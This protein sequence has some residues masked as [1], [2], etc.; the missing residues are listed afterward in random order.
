MKIKALLLLG[1][2][3]SIAVPSTALAG[4][5][6]LLNGYGAESLGM[7]GADVAVSR[8]S[9]ATNIN[10]AGLTQLTGSRLD[11]YA[12]PYYLTLSHSDAVGNDSDTTIPFGMIIGSAYASRSTQ[13]PGMVF[14]GGLYAQGGTGVGYDDLLTKFGTVD[15]I[16]SN[17]S[18][19]KAVLS[20]AWSVTD[21]LSAGL[22]L[23]LSYATGRQKYLP[24]SSDASDPTNPF[25]GV[26][27]DKG[28]N[29]SG[30]LIAGLQYRPWNNWTFAIAYTSETDLTLSGGTA[31]VNF[32]AI[33]EDRVRYENARFEGFNFPQE[34]DVGIAWQASPRWLLSAEFNWLDWSRALTTTRLV[35]NRPNNPNVPQTLAATTPVR[36]RD[37]YVTAFG[38]AYAYDER[39]VLRFGFNVS[40]DPVRKETDNPTFNVRQRSEFMIGYGRSLSDGWRYDLMLEHQMRETTRYQNPDLPLGDFAE[41][42]Y[43]AFLAIFSVSRSW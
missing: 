1:V 18:V 23:G 2:I 24:E 36:W 39:S 34:L 7:G 30:S 13:F 3:A 20:G 43:E 28:R 22:T 12:Y 16:S 10:P 17:I 38:L 42:Q 11:V 31:T 32:E 41:H 6:F 9:F 4:R 26:R 27:F 40:S 35:A 29:V 33:G 14:G 5:G 25:F 8:D 19:L 37:M 21:T 15:T